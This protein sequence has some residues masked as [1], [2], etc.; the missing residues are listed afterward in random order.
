MAITVRRTAD[1]P[2]F[3]LSQKHGKALLVEL[4]VRPARKLSG[5]LRAQAVVFAQ[6]EG[7]QG[8]QEGVFVAGS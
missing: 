3:P 1:P 7:V 2:H 5:Q 8:Q 6:E 4:L